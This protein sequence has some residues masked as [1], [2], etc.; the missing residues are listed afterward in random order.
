MQVRLNIPRYKCSR[1]HSGRVEKV[2]YSKQNLSRSS[3]VIDKVDCIEGQNPGIFLGKFLYNSFLTFYKIILDPHT[4][5]KIT[6]L[7]FFLFPLQAK[8]IT[9]MLNPAGDAQYAGRTIDGNFE[10]GITLQCC[11]QLKKILEYELNNTRIVLTRVPGETITHLQ[12]AS[13]S[14]RLQSDLFVSIHFF[15][16]KTGRPELHL[17]Y[18]SQN[19]PTESWSSPDPLQFIPYHKVYLLNLTTTKQISD[20]IYSLLQQDYKQD[21]TS[22]QPQGLPFAPLLG[23]AAPAVGIEMSLKKSDDWKLFIPGLKDSIKT[24]IK[25]L[26]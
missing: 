11:E 23:V 13:F 24:V 7:M 15:E 26:Q 6:C 22:H 2:F 1:I 18:F 4:T 5:L 21:F 19:N 9:I 3:R 20:S 17:Y 12:N 14:N 25:K 8:R 10:R 16:K